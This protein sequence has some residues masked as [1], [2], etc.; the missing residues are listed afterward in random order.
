MAVVFWL[1]FSRCAMRWRMRLMATRVSVRDPTGAGG[2]GVALGAEGAGLGAAGAGAV[3][4]AA[5]ALLTGAAAGGAGGA[6]AAF[7]A[8]AGAGTPV[9]IFASGAPTLTESSVRTQT[10]IG[11]EGGAYKRD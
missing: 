10:E 9:L 4:G 8:A 2:C 5:G 7:G 3:A 11:I 6:A 1:S